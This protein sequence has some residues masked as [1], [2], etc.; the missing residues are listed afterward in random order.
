MGKIRDFV[1]LDF[2]QFGISSI[3]DFVQFRILFIQDCVDFEKF[4]RS[5]F[6]PIRD[7]FPFG[8]LSNSGLCFSGFCPIRDFV[9]SGFFAFGILS[10]LGLC[11][12]GFCPIRDFVYSEFCPF[13]DFVRSGFCPIREYVRLEFCLFYNSNLGAMKFIFFFLELKI[14]IP[15]HIFT[16]LDLLDCIAKD[17]CCFLQT[18]IGFEAFVLSFFAIKGS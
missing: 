8:A 16:V 4:F 13:W 3:R 9:H 1:F 7:F 10:N 15:H 5:E 12:S 14:I 2:V 11:F 17:R 6:C 18:F